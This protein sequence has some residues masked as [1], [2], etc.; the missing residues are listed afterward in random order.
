MIPKS[1]TSSRTS[2]K[3]AT[4]PRRPA[5]TLVELLAGLALL[6]LLLSGMLMMRA[7]L[8]HQRAGADARLR[9]IAAA[10]ELLSTWNANPATFPRSNF[11]PCADPHFTWTTRIVPNTAAAT[12]AVQIIRLEIVRDNLPVTSVD[13]VLNAEATSTTSP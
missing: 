13:F 5:A 4:A 10:D 8:I 3:A 9:A 12:I 7:R 1:T 6:S 11:G 2:R